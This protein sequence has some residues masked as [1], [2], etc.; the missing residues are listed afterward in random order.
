MNSEAG[1]KKIQTCK[2]MEHNFGLQQNLEERHDKT[3]RK[4]LRSFGI[5]V[6]RLKI[7]RGRFVGLKV[8]KRFLY[9]YL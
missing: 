3:I 7:K 2:A 8:A 5:S 9:H 6:Q 4:V 1:M